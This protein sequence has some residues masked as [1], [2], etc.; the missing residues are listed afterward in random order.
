MVAAAADDEK[1]VPGG[2][3]V[4]GYEVVAEGPVETGRRLSGLDL[5]L[6]I[7]V[8]V[9]GRHFFQGIGIYVVD[10]GLDVDIEHLRRLRL[11]PDIGQ[12]QAIATNQCRG[13]LVGEHSLRVRHVDG[14]GYIVRIRAE[15]Q[16]VSGGAAEIIWRYPVLDKPGIY[17]GF[18]CDRCDRRVAIAGRE[19]VDDPL[20]SE[21][22]RLPIA[23][24]DRV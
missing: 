3:A 20:L 2:V 10:E 18:Q 11:R 13:E 4:D 15:D 23:T 6:V 5:N 14:V 7:Q 21:I 17:K 22:A 16:G 9:L 12:I 1:F 19:G 24:K 8:D